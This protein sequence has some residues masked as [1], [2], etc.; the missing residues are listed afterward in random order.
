MR[1]TTL[2]LRDGLQVGRLVESGGFTFESSRVFFF[3]EFRFLRL[4]KLLPPWF[5]FNGFELFS[6]GGNGLG[7]GMKRGEW[8]VE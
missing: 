8:N 4:D 5:P 3:G 6:W 2:I 1:A 7:C